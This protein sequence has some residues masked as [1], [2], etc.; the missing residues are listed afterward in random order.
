MKL[1]EST[2]NEQEFW[3]KIRV[4][5]ESGHFIKTIT[6]SNHSFKFTSK[7]ARFLHMLCMLIKLIIV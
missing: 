4:M 5:G 6:T 3:T 1:L 7:I 2:I